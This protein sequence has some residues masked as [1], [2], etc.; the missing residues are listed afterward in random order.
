MA[1]KDKEVQLSEDIFEDYRSSDRKT[2]IQ[3]VEDDRAFVAN[4]QIPSDI[5]DANNAANQPILTINET[6]PARD[7]VVSNL[8]KNSPRWMSYGKEKS[9]V[10]VAAKLADLME[11]IWY[12]SNGDMKNAKATEDF[13]DTGMWCMMAYADPTADYNRGEIFITDLDPAEVYIDPNSKREDTED[14]THKLIVKRCT[15]EYIQ[16]VYPDFDFEGAQASNDDDIPTSNYEPS[17]GQILKVTENQ[18]RQGDNAYYLL[19]DRYTKIKSPR[20][21]IQDREIEH[22]FTEEERNKYWQEPAVILVRR[23]REDY[24]TDNDQI[25]YWLNV[26]RTMGDVVH[27]MAFPEV[28]PDGQITQRLELMPGVEHSNAVPYS[29]TKIEEVNKGYFIELGVIKMTEVLVDRIKRVFSIG[30]KLYYKDTLPVSLHTI[31][32]AMNHHKRNPYPLGDIRYVR[33]LQEQLNKI[34]SKITAY[35][36]AIANLLAFIPKGGNLKKQIQ[37]EAGKGGLK[38]F[39]YD[40]ELDGGGVVFGQYPPLPAGVFQE[41]QNIINQIQRIMGAYPF[42]DG[43]ASQAPET[44]RATLVIQEE[45]QNRAQS[46]RKKIEE[47]INGLA[48][49]VAQLIPHVYTEKK[50]V[51]LL[52]PNNQVKET[53]FNDVSYENGAKQIINDLS[54]INADIVMV[55]GSMLP[56]NRWARS[57]YYTGLFE[58][59]ILQDASVI[60]RESEIPDVEQVIQKQDRERNLMQYVQQLE[61]QLKQSQGLLQTKSREVIQAQEKVAVEKTKSNLK[62]FETELKSKAQLAQMRM[63]DEVKKK[64]KDKKV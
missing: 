6:T 14:A 29:T 42:L 34:T 17:E 32:T 48:K 62:G 7:Q 4:V 2:W 57:E 13:I 50:I 26:R 8:T 55:S 16:T 25:Q 18:Q 44:Y 9:D 20:Y 63:G 59:G 61:Q 64:K 56:T 49:V 15:K 11:H 22:L 51:R 40:A 37:E 54:T 46:K 27:Y 23:G 12:I 43:D 47:G 45:G 5:I 36:S 21:H 38:V 60:L 10:N 19:I 41:R 28:T 33:P 30:G 58:K 53:V 39:E 31:R 1:D 35:I 3:N 52:K 24:V